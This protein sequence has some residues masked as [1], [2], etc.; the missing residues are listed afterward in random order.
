MR[1]APE[2]HVPAPKARPAGQITTGDRARI[3]ERRETLL[4]QL[5]AR[6]GPLAAEV[7][8]RVE[9]LPP[10]RLR[11]LLLDLIKAQSLSDLHLE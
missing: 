4:L 5:E 2:V 9:A 8:Q 3:E 7:R 6:F 11:P 10:E 1:G